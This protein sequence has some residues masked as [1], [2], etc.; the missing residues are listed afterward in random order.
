M[1]SDEGAQRPGPRQSVPW[2]VSFIGGLSV[3]ALAMLC[4]AA[5]Q[6]FM[7]SSARYTGPINPEGARQTASWLLGHVP[8]ALSAGAFVWVF[9]TL[10]V[11]TW[12][13]YAVAILSALRAGK[14]SA[15]WPLIAAGLLA[16]TLAVVFPPSLSHD[17]YA[18]L[19]MGRM[20]ALYGWNPYVHTLR[21]FALLGDPAAIHYPTGA[22]SVYGPVWA[23]LSSGLAG[24]LRSLPLP[25]QL[26]AFKLVGA[27]AL[28]WAGL[29]ARSV[30]RVWDPAHADVAL[31]AL[32]FNPLLL[33]EGPCNGHNDVLMIAL[34]LAGVALVL[35][36]ARLGWFVVGLS[37]GV[38]FVTLAIVPWL[39]Y[40]QV[41]SMRLSRALARAATAVALVLAPVALLFIPYWTGSR[42]L[43]GIHAVWAAK[44][45][46]NVGAG[47]GVV[48]C[49]IVYLAASLWLLRG[50]DD[51]VAPAWTVWSISFALLAMPVIL[52]WYMCW[53]TALT[54]TRW[55]R[56]QRLLTT[57]CVILGIVL[58]FRY[59]LLR[60]G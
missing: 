54:L 30:A 4:L 24:V 60:A 49:A 5:L 7:P 56:R 10:L 19:G 12:I 47:A 27:A 35:R 55:D 46:G 31:V 44:A 25:A 45:S 41:R 58:S 32:V 38:K 52:P 11:A 22:P 14:V 48:L 36:S 33:L 40:Q 26:I 9:R 37:V 21:E 2:R 59:T 23:L 17:L 34:L 1:T 39:I 53:P 18:Y 50:N 29:S 8:T 6:Y 16:A 51:R 57:A 43:G 13:G 20:S 28:V 3:L 42:T 15:R